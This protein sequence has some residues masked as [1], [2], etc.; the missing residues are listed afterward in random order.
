[1]ILLILTLPN[2][3]MTTKLPE[4]DFSCLW[5]VQIWWNWIWKSNK[6]KDHRNRRNGNICLWN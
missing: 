5:T 2:P 1:M 4:T 6:I 3:N